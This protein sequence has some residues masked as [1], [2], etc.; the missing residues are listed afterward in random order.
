M[1]EQSVDRAGKRYRIE[2]ICDGVPPS[3][4]SEAAIDTREE[5][6]HR[7]RGFGW[8]TGGFAGRFQPTEG[9]SKL[10]QAQA[11]LEGFIDPLHITPGEPTDSLF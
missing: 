9:Q 5:F 8:S 11:D 7:R 6:G 1:R 3:A 4:G 2:L 10:D